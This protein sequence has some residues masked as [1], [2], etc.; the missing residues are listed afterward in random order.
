MKISVIIPAFNRERFIVP[1]LRSLARQRTDKIDLDIIVVDDGSTDGTAHA[2][3][4]FAEDAPFVRLV[5]KENGGP[6]SARNAGLKNL[7]PGTELIAFLDSDDIC[8]DGRFAKE[9]PLF[10]TDP[11]LGLTYAK[12]TIC[13]ALDDERLEPAEGAKRET[14]RSVSVTTCLFRRAV[15]E[16]AGG[17]D[18]TLIHA[19]D[20]DFLIRLFEQ[21]VRYELMDHVAILYRR[22]PGNMTKLVQKGREYLKKVALKSAFRRSRTHEKKPLPVFFDGSDLRDWDNK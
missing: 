11:A 9:V 13:S 21:D 4:A 18:E 8:V 15:L 1:A 19:E 10:E 16:R 17:F 3:T 12:L 7:L 2:V 5:R 6:S 14:L 22:H 20:W